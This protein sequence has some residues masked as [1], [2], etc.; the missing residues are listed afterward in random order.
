M[1]PQVHA[2][3]QRRYTHYPRQ[4]R[5][6]CRCS[7]ANIADVGTSLTRQMFEKMKAAAETKQGE[8]QCWQSPPWIWH[9]GICSGQ[10]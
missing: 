7:A 8:H 6:A 9:A 10:A 3:L 2:A 1:F 4:R 5:L